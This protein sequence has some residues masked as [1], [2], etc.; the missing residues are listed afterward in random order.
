MS[1]IKAF[2]VS[3]LRE[4]STWR[5]IVALLT[6][7]GIVLSPEQAEAV[8]AAGLAIIGMIGTLAPDTKA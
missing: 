4:A 8:I 7:L 6:S 3:R 2:I 1:E 5:G